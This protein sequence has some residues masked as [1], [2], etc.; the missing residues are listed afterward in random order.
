VISDNWFDLLPCVPV[1]VR[2]AKGVKAEDVRLE[3]VVS[4]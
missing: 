2:L 4:R 1:R 3:A